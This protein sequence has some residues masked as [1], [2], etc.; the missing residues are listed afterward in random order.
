MDRNKLLFSIWTLLFLPLI[1]VPL[2]SSQD[3]S[4][5][6]FAELKNAI[7]SC[8][9]VNVLSGITITENIDISNDIVFKGTGN[10]ELTFDNVAFNILP[11]TDATFNQLKFAS[12]EANTILTAQQDST[13]SFD[14]CG[15]SN[16]HFELTSTGSVAS[17][18]NSEFSNSIEFNDANPGSN[19]YELYSNF[20]SSSTNGN[21]GLSLNGDGNLE[22]NEFESCSDSCFV[23]NGGFVN[24]S[25]HEF[26]DFCHGYECIKGK[27]GTHLKIEHNYFNGCGDTSSC[28]HFNDYSSFEMFNNTFERGQTHVSSQSRLSDIAINNNVFLRSAG[29]SVDFGGITYETLEMHNNVFRFNHG[30][31]GSEFITAAQGNYTGNCFID[32]ASK[33]QSSAGAAFSGNWWGHPTGPHGLGTAA[34]PNIEPH[35]ATRPLDICPSAMSISLIN[36]QQWYD[37]ADIKFNIECNEEIMGSGACSSLTA[38]IGHEGGWS[39][40]SSQD[41]LNS[42]SPGNHSFDGTSSYPSELKY[43]LSVSSQDYNFMIYSFEHFEIDRKSIEIEMQSLVQIY[44]H[45]NETLEVNWEAQGRNTREVELFLVSDDWKTEIH[46]TEDRGPY[47]WTIDTYG[48]GSGEYSIQIQ[49]LNYPELSAQTRAVSIATVDKYIKNVE[50]DPSH[51]LSNGSSISVT[52]DTEGTIEEVAISIYHLEDDSE[53]LYEWVGNNTGVH[54]FD[55]LL[56]P[57]TRTGQYSGEV[58]STEYIGVGELNGYLFS[59]H[60]NVKITD[61]TNSVLNGESFT[62]HWTSL[63][64]LDAVEVTVQTLGSYPKE[65]AYWEG[66]DTGSHTFESITGSVPSRDEQKELEVKVQAKNWFE[67][68]DTQTFIL[69]KNVRLENVTFDPSSLVQD[70]YVYPGQGISIEWWAGPDLSE[71]YITLLE[72]ETGNLIYFAGSSQYIGTQFESSGGWNSLDLTVPDD[73]EVKLDYYERYSNNIIPGSY[74]LRIDDVNGDGNTLSSS[75]LGLDTEKKSL[76]SITLETEE[77]VEA[78][79]PVEF[80]LE[81]SGHLGELEFLAIVPDNDKLTFSCNIGDSYKSFECYLPS[82]IPSNNISIETYSKSYDFLGSVK[83][84]PFEL[85]T[86]IVLDFSFGDPADSYYVKDVDTID[87]KWG[88]VGGVLEPI[89]IF[90]AKQNWTEQIAS[91]VDGGSFEWNVDDYSQGRDYGYYFILQSHNFNDISAES[92]S[93]GIAFEVRDLSLTN[94]VPSQPLTG[95]PLTVEWNTTGG[96]E[97]V[98]IEVVSPHSGTLCQWSGTNM[99]SHTFENFSLANGVDEPGPGYVLYIRNQK[100]IEAQVKYSFTVNATQE[101]M[102]ITNA[103]L[104]PSSLVHGVYAYRGQDI[105][106]SWYQGALAGTEV[107]VALV[108]DER[109]TREHNLGRNIPVTGGT[110][111]TQTFEVPRVSRGNYF[112]KVSSTQNEASDTSTETWPIDY[113]K[114]ELS[115]SLETDARPGPFGIGWFDNGDQIN[116]SWE[117][118]GTLRDFEFFLVTNGSDS[119]E[120]TEEV[121]INKFRRNGYYTLSSNMSSIDVKIQM[122]SAAYPFVSADSESF[123]I[124][125]SGKN[126]TIQLDPAEEIYETHIDDLSV[127]WDKT[128]YIGEGFEVYLKGGPED[129][130]LD[131][132]DLEETDNRTMFEWN[133]VDY[134]PGEYY[135]E[136]VASANDEYSTVDLTAK[137][138]SFEIS[139]DD[140]IHDVVVMNSTEGYLV[141]DVD[142][143]LTWKTGEDS[144][145]L[146]NIYLYQN[147]NETHQLN[148]SV[149]T[150]LNASNSATVNL[151]PETG[152]GYSIVVVSKYSGVMGESRS[153]ELDTEMKSIQDLEISNR[154]LD[155]NTSAILTWN[156]TGN[157][158]TVSIELYSYNTSESYL[159]DTNVPA[160]WNQYDWNAELFNATDGYFSIVL[161]G[162]T[163]DF[164][165]AESDVFYLKLYRNVDIPSITPDRGYFMP[166]DSYEISQ[167]K[168]TGISLIDVY[169]RQLSEPAQSFYSYYS[170]LKESSDALNTI[171]LKKDADLSQG[172]IDIEIPPAEELSPGNYDLKI[173]GSNYPDVSMTSPQFGVDTTVKTVSINEISSENYQAGGSLNVSWSTTGLIETI[174]IRLE[175]PSEV[176]EGTAQEFPNLGN[177]EYILSKNLTGGNYQL[178]VGPPQFDDKVLTSQ[179]IY[180]QPQSDISSSESSSDSSVILS[181]SSSVSTSEVSKSSSSLENSSSSSSSQ[182]ESESSSSVIIPSESDSQSSS[183]QPPISSSESHSSDSQS[184]SQESSSIHSQSLSESSSGTSSDSQ[185]ES[186]SESSSTQSSS[187]SIFISESHSAS[188][189]SSS[190]Q[191]SSSEPK[192]SFSS[193]SVVSDSDSKSSVQSSSSESSSSEPESSSSS[194]T[195]SESS[196]QSTYE[197]IS[198]SESKSSSS[199][200]EQSIISSTSSQVSSSS[201]SSSKSESSAS[202]DNEVNLSDLN[203]EFTNNDEALRLTWNT[204]GNVENVRIQVYRQGAQNPIFTTQVMQNEG[205]YILSPRGMDLDQYAGE[206]L[207]IEVTAPER[208]N[209]S[210]EDDIEIPSENSSSGNNN[211]DS[212][213]EDYNSENSESVLNEGNYLKPNIKFVITC[214]ISMIVTVVMF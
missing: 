71:I 94:M 191:S 214:I 125:T 126:V 48:K 141:S 130:L 178:V 55:L 213:S 173:Q 57:D 171:L 86:E 14:G 195:S 148:D 116:L 6:D 1:F 8:S 99:G 13:V 30:R 50:V 172:P 166:N 170:V 106:V 82:N 142:Y 42:I 194:H 185:S 36:K 198:S 21:G 108:L 114:K 156:S 60:K 70:T 103:K 87:V 83:T 58:Y 41:S 25:N 85:K 104:V 9:E 183:T 199:S 111:N 78:S 149:L 15:I 11:N 101:Q 196:S 119:T 160:S 76:D 139:G 44:F 28:V 192:P 24:I 143:T 5:D 69:M 66:Q 129:V 84:K 107:S 212:E 89:D 205:N 56:T 113:E 10:P 91:Q 159:I 180:I 150:S 209:V 98:E 174:E 181:E 165:E 29:T 96:I 64:D 59:I 26:S 137:T 127:Y 122:R 193:S 138:I 136:F 46:R 27:K 93:F 189:S 154:E 97:D 34:N 152:F 123:E 68:R 211:N 140:S 74:K 175:N 188:E 2:G 63:G 95:T 72:E 182:P 134:Y 210:T 81:A 147:G 23:L 124:D 7:S 202:D 169:L 62:V 3:C 163:Y 52:W 144:G 158:G 61:Y 207:H 118:S 53:I 43:W 200:S 120:I 110:T 208:D 79:E 33:V 54:S 153:F 73:G 168:G 115:I 146:F 20:I 75:S 164:L 18:S 51:D 88:T 131:F 38:K 92:D 112:V 31:G 121:D 40:F 179:S 190:V 201:V 102:S 90:L 22:E 151:P 4:A 135:I 32:T 105:Q 161:T 184:S 100:Y 45:V 77:P 204:Q 206:T 187:E 65:I 16:S 203:V 47:E 176:V 12:T 37:S 157:C 167:L 80:S 67:A 117:D 133:P 186:N 49:S 128:G 145:D 197:S 39:A 132:V 155:T 35:F 19:S 177:A 109:F 162:E 17:F